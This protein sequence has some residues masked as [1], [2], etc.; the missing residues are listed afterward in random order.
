MGHELLVAWFLPILVVFFAA[1]VQGTAGFAFGVLSMA[2]LT[3]LWEPKQANVVVTLLAIWSSCHALFSLRGAVRWPRVV[4]LLL[5]LL[6]G[7]PLGTQALVAPDAEVL[8]RRLVALACVLAAA[9]NWGPP[10]LPREGHQARPWRLTGWLAG[11]ASGFLAGSVSSG[12][13]PILWYVYR[14]PWSREELKATTLA[15]FLAA[16]LLKLVFWGAYDLAGPPAGDL[17][18][19]PRLLLALALLPAVAVGTELGIRI[20]RRVDREQLRRMACLLL[21]AMAALV[22][23]TA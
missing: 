18:T 12:G 10:A 19:A 2:F 17:L 1:L 13:P 15:V 16:S 20:F 11:T 7:L 22:S 4:D 5:G 9:Q 8:L 21:L 6:V 23:A 14:Q 3:L